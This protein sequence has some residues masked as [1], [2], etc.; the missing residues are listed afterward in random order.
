MRWVRSYNSYS[1]PFVCST[2]TLPSLSSGSDKDKDQED[3]T[4]VFVAIFFLFA[5]AAAWGFLIYRRRKID[6]SRGLKREIK[7]MNSELNTYKNAAVGM[8]VAVTR[9]GL[10]WPV[11]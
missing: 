9:P 6:R 4:V 8:R 1:R 3:N 5:L 7:R 2:T 11:Q 10:R